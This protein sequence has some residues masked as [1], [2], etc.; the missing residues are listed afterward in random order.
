[1]RGFWRL[2]AEAEQATGSLRGL[3]GPRP[4]LPAPSQSP[5]CFLR[6]IEFWYLHLIPTTSR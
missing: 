6:K 5:T 1:M 2:S 3:S 4:A